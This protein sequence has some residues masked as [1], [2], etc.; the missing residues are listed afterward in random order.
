MEKIKL[1]KL[2]ISLKVLCTC[3]ILTI[4]LGYAVS[5]VQIFDRTH[6]DMVET[7]TYYRGGDTGEEE[8][9][10]VPQ[11]FKTML[12]V[13]HVHTLSQPMMFALIGLIFV[14]SSAAERAKVFFIVLLFAGSIA[15]NATPWLV[16]YIGPGMVYLF[17]LSQF[18]ITI[19]LAAASLVSLDEMWF[20][21][22]RM[23]KWINQK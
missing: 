6:F 11:S 19:G 5:L 4:L 21:Q 14:F 8:E 13:A 7:V 3:Y 22:R 16:R 10:F 15:S 1:L 17:P 18:T 9:L 20:K 12:S 23:A 2:P